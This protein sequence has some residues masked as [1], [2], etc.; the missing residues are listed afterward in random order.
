MTTQA[1]TLR[2][3]AD[4][5]FHIRERSAGR[6]GLLTCRR[7]GR[8]ETLSTSD[9]L[10][11]IHSLALAL[12]ARGLEAGQRVAI[13][14]EARPEWHLVDLACQLLGAVTVPIDPAADRDLTGFIL[15]NS[16]CRWAFYGWG[17]KRDLLVA[18]QQGLTEPLRLVAFDAQH[19]A[20]DGLTITLLMGE[21]APR[22][23]D[24]PLERFRGKARED[25]LATILYTSGTTGD[26]KGVMLSQRNLTSNALACGKVF[27]LDSSDLAVTFLSP[28]HGF[29]RTMDHL[30]LYRGAAIHYVPSDEEMPTALRQEQPS[31]LVA[32][33]RVYE[34]AYHRTLEMI[35]DQ[36]PWK[37]RLFHWSVAVGR[38]YLEASRNGFIGPLLAIERRLAERLAFSSIKRRFGGRLRIALC[39]GGPLSAEVSS[40]FDA[41][42]IAVDQGYGLAETS[43]V[44]TTNAPQRRR[45]GSVGKA[46]EAVEMRLADDGEILARGPGVMM[47][48]WQ[49]PA[50][51]A[52]TLDESGWLH[53][54]DVG[55][56]DQSG[57]VFITARKQDLL[58]MQDGQSIAPHPLE[59]QLSH[60]EW[61]A[62]AMVIGDNRPYLAALLV[63]DFDRL[64]SLPGVEGSPPSEELVTSVSVRAAAADLLARVNARQGD[65]P[66][67]KRFLVLSR[68]FS[69]ENGEVSLSG[70]LRR[71]TI[72]QRWAPAIAE[73][74]ATAE[75]DPKTPVVA[76]EPGD[77]TPL[78]AVP[79]APAPEDP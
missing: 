55:R 37:Q 60:G 23:G 8:R 79:S 76:D 63:P 13:F 71:P 28:A 9:V 50:A 36:G 62:Q 1:P 11:G 69:T 56:I 78:S 21:G 43:P 19:A 68:A 25:D 49:D 5:V 14:S 57:Y 26:P 15:R 31:L 35:D 32:L 12:E 18:L 77:D 17:G 58:V 7:Q 2:T 61:V 54:G 53:T 10:R 67:I 72:L 38:R 45:L 44:L 66:K 46:L 16:G 40:F 75:V 59:E 20:A 51:T 22:Q 74:Y 47:G 34:R 64:R 48:Y 6:P 24:V 29:Q 30:C 33:P 39:G 27:R 41:V 73:L 52:R 4:L 65:G 3:L 70:E 42:G